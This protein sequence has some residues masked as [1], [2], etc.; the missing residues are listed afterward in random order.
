MGWRPRWTVE[1]ALQETIAWYRDWLGRR[2]ERLARPTRS[3]EAGR[4]AVA[5]APARVRG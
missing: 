4:K 5:D 3:G 2:D 1:D